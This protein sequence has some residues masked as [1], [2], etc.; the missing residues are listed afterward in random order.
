MSVMIGI[1]LFSP[2]I[3]NLGSSVMW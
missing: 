3:L 1:H 2:S